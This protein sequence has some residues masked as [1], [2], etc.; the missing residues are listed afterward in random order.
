MNAI[1]DR[2]RETA[3]APQFG[4]GLSGVLPRRQPASNSNI[5]SSLTQRKPFRGESS[6]EQQSFIERAPFALFTRTRV[7]HSGSP[8][9]GS[10]AHSALSLPPPPPQPLS[11]PRSEASADASASAASASGLSSSNAGRY[12][13]VDRVQSLMRA[14]GDSHN[15]RVARRDREINRG[16]SLSVR[17][18]A[19]HSSSSF[20]E[21]QFA[22]PKRYQT[23]PFGLAARARPTLQALALSLTSRSNPNS[24][25]STRFLERTTN[26][27]EQA[28]IDTLNSLLAVINTRKRR[29]QEVGFFSFDSL[30]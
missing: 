26:F 21:Q 19:G 30:F 14:I 17:L 6:F 5:A 10:P 12:E 11:R 9:F 8:A 13:L 1:I 2:V 29:L 28:D 18:A 15:P 3:D 24:Q 4:I 23:P 7:T 16:K 27:I 20:S 25:P 22:L